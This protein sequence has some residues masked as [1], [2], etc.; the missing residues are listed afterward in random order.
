MT[1]VTRPEKLKR[2]GLGLRHSTSPD[3]FLM[4]LTLMYFLVSRSANLGFRFDSP[5][6][7][8]VMT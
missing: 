1:R 2:S 5:S 6:R 3:R 7:L 8:A 4:K